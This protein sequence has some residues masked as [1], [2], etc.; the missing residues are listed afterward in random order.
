M[1]TSLKKRIMLAAGASM[2]SLTGLAVAAPSQPARPVPPAPAKPAFAVGDMIQTNRPTPVWTTPPTGG[3][4][5]GKQPVRATGRI[6]ANP[7]RAAD[8]S[9]WKVDFANQSDGW[10]DQRDLSKAGDARPVPPPHEEEEAEDSAGSS[11][12]I[13]HF[14]PGNGRIINSN[15][16]MLSGT[17]ASDIYPSRLIEA[18]LNG[19]RVKLDP[20]GNF[21]VLAEA[22]PGKNIYTLRASVPN[23]RQQITSVSTFMDASMVYGSDAVRANALRTFQGGLL[24][25]SDGDLLPYNTAL[26]PN[27]NDAH[28]FSDD[29][30]FLAGDVRANEN[31]ELTAIHILFLREHNLLARAI[32]EANPGL[33]DEKIYQQA[34]RL[35]AAEIQ[36]IT[37]REFLPALLGSRAVRPY[38]GYRPGV[39]PGLAT[40][41]STAAFRIGHTM[42]NDDVEFLDNDGEEIRDELPLAFAFFNPA[43]LEETGPDPLLKYLAIDNAQ[44]IDT[45]LVDGLRDFLFGPPGAGGL[46]LASLNIQR[47]RDHGLPGYNAVRRAYGLPAVT[48]FAG[49][50]RDGE[51]QKKLAALYGSVDSIDLWVAGLAEDHLPGSSVGPTFARIIVDQFERMRDGDRN[52]YERIFSGRQLE[53]LQA[54]RLSDIIRRNTSITKIQDNVFFFDPDTTLAGLVEKSGVLPPALFGGSGLS[55]PPAALDGSGNNPVHPYWGSAGADLL[56]FSSAAYSDGISGPSGDVRPGARLISN[57]LCV[58]TAAESNDRDMSS[59]VYGWGQ[60]IDHDIGLTTTGDTAFDIPVPKGDPSFDPDSTGGAVIPFTRSNYDTT[61]GNGTPV[62]AEQKNTITVRLPAPPPEKKPAPRD[63]KKPAPRPR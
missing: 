26:F 61:T 23:P 42:V 33:N 12:T 8:R 24:K 9:W 59:W 15:R 32:A 3:A 5:A 35:V 46:D 11:L 44:E 7:V 53:A 50:T 36:A 13:T 45:K 6:V 47:G 31:A 27:A 22:K 38:A 49:I 4:L 1:K 63:G 62:V 10:V 18:T 29:K 2:L 58:Q 34:R 20:A 14:T 40:E 60:F 54:T 43:L 37:Y 21:T 28:I 19:T 39:N 25:T 51:V 55:V 57:Q 52:W 41:F 56:R 48:S 16:L 30:L 17:I